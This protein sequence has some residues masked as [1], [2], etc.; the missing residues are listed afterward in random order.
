[1]IRKQITSVLLSLVLAA[2]VFCSLFAQMPAYAAEDTADEETDMEGDQ[3]S[4]PG[5]E[6]EEAGNSGEEAYA[7]EEKLNDEGDV[8]GETDASDSSGEV[9]EDTALP[10]DE[11]DSESGDDN[12]DDF[13][14]KGTVSI[15]TK[16]REI[17]PEDTSGKSSEDLFAEYVDKSFGVQTGQTSSGRKRAPKNAASGL[18]GID[19][20]IYDEIAA[21]LPAIAAGERASTVFEISV[22][23]LGLDKTY[24][25]AEELGFESLFVLDEDGEYVTDEDGFVIISD[26]AASAVNAKGDYD[27]NRI[28]NALLADFPYHLYWYEKSQSTLAA[29]AGI[30]GWYDETV[31]D[32]VLGLEGSISLS[33][34]VAGEYSAGEYLVDTSIGQSVQTSVENANAI[35]SKYSEEEDLDKLSGYKEEICNLVSYNYEAAGGGASYG[36]P[37]QMIWVFDDDP[38]TNVVCEGYSKAFQYLCDRSDFSD[39][40]ICAYSVSGTMT[41]GTGAGPHMWNIV[42]L[43]DG[44]HYLADI[45]NS[46]SGTV[47]ED[48]ELFIAPYTSGSVQEGYTFLCSDDTDI[49]YAYDDDNFSIFSEEDLTIASSAYGNEPLEITSQPQDVSAEAGETVILHVEANRSNVTYQWQWRTGSTNWK[50]CTSGGYNRDSFSFMMKETLAGRL[51]RCKVTGSGET[52][53]SEAARITLLFSPFEITIQPQNVSAKAGEDVVLHVETN[54]SDVTYQWQYSINGTTWKNCSSAGYNTDTFSFMM[55]ATLSGRQ[56]R[57]RVTSGGETLIS[58]A[59]TITLR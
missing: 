18:T 52:L 21:C 39:G 33:F 46:D 25:T 48:G 13:I 41:G 7:F 49:H 9:I 17:I 23:E 16:D 56:Y 47:G 29:G 45:T 19:R 50:N 6:D 30:T 5:A 36:N 8:K 24:W 4:R 40:K 37:W 44:N 27:L 15:T 10:D 57:C 55:K 22:D 51:Y 53:T 32:Y 20:V 1:M 14:F 43:D 54:K 34:P 11:P 26:E 38:D 31:D 35:V 3:T 12:A 42:T 59:G 2:S 28:V 58:E